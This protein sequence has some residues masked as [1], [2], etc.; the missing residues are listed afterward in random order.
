[1]DGRL[2]IDSAPA[3]RQAALRGLGIAML[4]SML[5]SDD[6]RRKRLVEILPD[7]A[8]P[9]RPVHLLYLRERQK[10]PKLQSFIEFITERFATD[11]AYRRGM[12]VPTAR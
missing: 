8:A 2:K 3:L 10:S 9:Q 12:K 6:I 4:P 5:V 1:V 11:A 7:Y